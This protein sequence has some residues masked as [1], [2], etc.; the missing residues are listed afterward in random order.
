MKFA[1][2]IMWTSHTTYN[3]YKEVCGVEDANSMALF[4][5]KESHAE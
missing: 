2:H 4:G 1:L 3:I 5:A